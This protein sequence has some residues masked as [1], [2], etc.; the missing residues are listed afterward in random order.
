MVDPELLSMLRSPETHQPLRLANSADL[1]SVNQRIAAGTLK[2]RGGKPVA[3]SLQAGLIRED[4]QFI[5]AIRNDIPIM[6]IE[7]AIPLST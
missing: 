6:L 1:A 7:E 2:N 3:D 4:G 5:Y